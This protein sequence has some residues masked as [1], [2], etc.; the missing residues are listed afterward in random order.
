MIV[1]NN[2]FKKFQKLNC[3]NFRKNRMKE[4]LLLKLFRE[5]IFLQTLLILMKF[6]I[7]SQKNVIRGIHYQIKPIG[8]E[9]LVTVLKEK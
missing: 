8:L 9:K 7:Q 1:N 4:D 6:I 2:I 3:L 5:K